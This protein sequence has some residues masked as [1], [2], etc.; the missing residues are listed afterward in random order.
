M[1]FNAQQL[2]YSIAVRFYPG[3]PEESG[4]RPRVGNHHGRSVDGALSQGGAVLASAGEEARRWLG[5]RVA[6]RHRCTGA[7]AAPATIAALA[8]FV[9]VAART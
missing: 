5:R 4:K 1:V 8:D 9:A 6:R 7:L 2:R 3:E